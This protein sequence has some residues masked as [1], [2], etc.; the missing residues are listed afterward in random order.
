LATVKVAVVEPAG[1]V[2]TRGSAALES[3]VLNRIVAP[4]EG[5]GPESTIVHEMVL[6]GIRL[7]GLHCRET[8]VTAAERARFTL[9][10][11]PP[12]D[13]VIEPL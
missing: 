11:T 7:G 2:A 4:P 3:V 13:A 9:C 5:A 1:T 8:I 12:Y 6:F 10:D